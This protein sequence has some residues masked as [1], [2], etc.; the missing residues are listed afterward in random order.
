MKN[1]IEVIKEEPQV[2]ENFTRDEVES[3]LL[4]LAEHYGGT[5]SK[6]DVEEFNEWMEFNF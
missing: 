1:K 6:Q 3:L 2:K 4:Q 5:S